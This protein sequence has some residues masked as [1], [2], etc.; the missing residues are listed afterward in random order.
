[1]TRTILVSGGSGYIAGFLIRQLVSEGWTV[2]ATIRDPAREPALRASL[3]VEDDRLLLFAADLS[4]DAG[5]AD[6]M[7]GCTHVAHVASPLPIGQ[8]TDENELVVPAR[9]GALRVLRAA[10]A[11]RVRRFVMTSSIAA[12]AHGHPVAQRRFT[13]ADW[14][15][16]DGAD[17]TPY[18]KSKTV[19]ERAARDW[20]ASD[21]GD[22]EY[23]TVNPSL[24]IGPVMSAD[25]SG[26]M[27]IIKALIEG[28]FK[29]SPNIGFGVVD[30]RDVAAMHAL[31]LT[32]PG[33]AGERFI[34]SGPFYTI[35]D[36]ARV[37]RT[38]L[39]TDAAR[40]K[41][42][43]LPDWLV[44]LSALVNPMARQVVP[45]LGRVREMDASHAETVLGWRAR[46]VDDTIVDAARSLLDLGL[47]TR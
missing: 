28:T 5:W 40:V 17:V 15:R 32:T 2:H 36:I 42:R 10:K 11:A 3:A 26:S 37:L 23:C 4:S 13:E 31:L 8:V 41:V 6:A 1:M 39:G 25:F 29:G 20:M 45:E 27:Q 46:P 34:A 12:I 33:M 7:D 19:A 35:A 38:R 43:S 22:M 47:V 18:I 21:G 24:V 9:E 44:R 30:V 16:I 14:T